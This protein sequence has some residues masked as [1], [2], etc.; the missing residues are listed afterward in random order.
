[1]VL[2]P[3][4]DPTYDTT[5]FWP[6]ARIDV[7]KT[8]NKWLKERPASDSTYYNF[9]RI[10]WTNNSGMQIIKGEI[11]QQSPL[12]TKISTRKY[13]QAFS[14]GDL[15]ILPGTDTTLF[16]LEPVYTWIDGSFRMVIA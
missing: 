4:D 13:F 15:E 5:R 1:M 2:V 3:L 16:S 8:L 9:D 14:T 11:D 10:A 7:S 12:F 6:G